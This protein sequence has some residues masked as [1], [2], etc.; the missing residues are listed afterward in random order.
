MKKFLLIAFLA[1]GIGAANA[2]VTVEGSKFTDNWSLTL[3]GGAVSPFQHYSV[4]KNSRGLVG[5]ELRKQITPVFGFAL[6]YSAA[7]NNSSWN[8]KYGGI[9]SNNVFDSQNL[10]LVGV[11]NLNNLFAGY[12]GSPRLFEIET[13]VGTGWGHIFYPSSVDADYNVMTAKAGLNLNFNLGESKAWTIGIKP[14]VVWNLSSPA[15][16]S[17]NSFNANKAA[18]ELTAGI[19]YHFKN[20]NGTHSFKIADLSNQAEIDALNNRINALRGELAD[21]K[22]ALDECNNRPEKVKEVV[23]EVEVIKEVA[24]KSDVPETI[25]TFDQGK[26]VISKAQYPNVQRV[27]TYLKS[28]KD[29][30]VTILGYASPEGSIEINQKLSKAR[31]NAVKDMLVNTY[32]I[33]ADRI[34]ADGQG[35]GD[36]FEEPD[37]NRVSICT[38][39]K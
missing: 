36:V 4:I 10:M 20:S 16:Q 33:S 5:L 24:K 17:Y 12:A 27:A 15:K 26:S 21:T 18:L 32:K 35:V 13:V 29:A 25:I 37:W 7:V 1:L 31:A 9:K 19:T 6:D 23:K 39:E 22:R 38:I 34:T 8:L 3:K 28:H 14:A 30:K 2:Q 11:T